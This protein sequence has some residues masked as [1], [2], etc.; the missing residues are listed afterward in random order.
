MNCGRGRTGSLP[1]Y[2]HSHY[3]DVLTLLYG[4]I[5]VFI[6]PR[7]MVSGLRPHIA[8]QNQMPP[9]SALYISAMAW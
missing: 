6:I 4:V 9:K 7:Q 2:A 1:F 8:R 3:F 5:Y